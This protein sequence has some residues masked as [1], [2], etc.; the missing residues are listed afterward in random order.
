MSKHSTRAVLVA[1]IAAAVALPSAAQATWRHKDGHRDHY[2]HTYKDDCFHKTYRDVRRSTTRV[3][4]RTDRMFKDLF[5]WC[6]HGKYKH[7][8]YR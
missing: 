2:R 8:R 7:R 1:A 3:V 5:R 6:D 4:D